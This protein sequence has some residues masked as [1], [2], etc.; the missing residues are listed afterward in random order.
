MNNRVKRLILFAQAVAGDIKA[1]KLKIGNTDT[2]VT[3][4]KTSTVNAINEV[5][6]SSKEI[7][8]AMKKFSDGL[9]LNQEI[10]NAF[11]ISIDP[12]EI[13]L[14]NIK[15]S[16]G[17]NEQ[18]T[19]EEQLDRNN[20]TL[21]ADNNHKVV[22]WYSPDN[23]NTVNQVNQGT[24]SKY[25]KNT[26]ADTTFSLPEEID[27]TKPFNIKQYNLYKKLRNKT[28]FIPFQEY[29]K[30]N[31]Q[32]REIAEMKIDDINSL[33]DL[34]NSGY[35]S[36]PMGGTD[37]NVAHLL[38]KVNAERQITDAEKNK[39]YGQ[40]GNSI[41]RIRLFVNNDYSKYFNIQTNTWNSM[42]EIADFSGFADIII[43]KFRDINNISG[44][45]K[46][47]NKQDENGNAIKI[48]N[49]IVLTPDFSKAKVYG[50]TITLP[51]DTKNIIS[52]ILNNIYTDNSSNYNNVYTDFNDMLN[53]TNDSPLK[54]CIIDKNELNTQKLYEKMETPEAKNYLII[55]DDL[56]EQ[57]NYVTDNAWVPVS[58]TIKNIISD[59][60][61]RN[62]Q[63]AINKI[64]AK[65]TEAKIIKALD[66][67]EIDWTSIV[68]INIDT[69][70][71]N[72]ANINSLIGTKEIV[73][74]ETYENFVDNNN[75]DLSHTKVYSCNY[76]TKSVNENYDN[77]LIKIPNLKV[78]NVRF[79]D[80]HK[81]LLKE[82][83]SHGV[84]ALNCTFN[85]YPNTHKIIYVYSEG[86]WLQY[87]EGQLFEKVKDI[88]DFGSN[89][90][91]ASLD[92]L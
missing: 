85:S 34:N 8:D 62:I 26:S 45:I 23:F 11:N 77:I 20:T 16:L 83:E 3:D 68:N 58:E 35:L 78:I 42:S 52:N 86:E 25:F 63:Y 70:T 72:W 24:F 91:V 79:N 21:I 92:N 30:K 76:S 67:A 33:H 48:I 27:V 69:R 28:N 36:P 56:K 4:D 7:K 75:I 6:G 31:I 39:I 54:I 59:T 1:L 73:Q 18:E 19:P 14:P 37:L 2:L 82:L 88:L 13:L 5:A 74:N 55:S 32:L 44:I 15:E 80:N 29:I 9:G 17:A 41:H 53:A 43:S 51:A 12:F 49:D 84:I 89:T 81:N 64:K 40:Y 50:H 57:Y 10:V 71:T 87:T 61:N 38:I 60:Y 22:Y 90:V 46:A 66:K 47:I 65:K